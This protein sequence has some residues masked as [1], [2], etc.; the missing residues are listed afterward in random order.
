MPSSVAI[1]IEASVC[2][3]RCTFEFVI[4]NFTWTWVPT[5][6]TELTLPTDTPPTSTWSPGRNPAASAK[7]AT[8][9]APL[10][11]KLYYHRG[12]KQP[13]LLKRDV[14]VTGDELTDARTAATQDGPGVSIKLNSR[15][16]ART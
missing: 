4:R 5:R 6:E 14:I 16:G 7:S 11:S 10:G 8:G 15:G 3:P 1:W 2:D 13:I 9:R 12:T